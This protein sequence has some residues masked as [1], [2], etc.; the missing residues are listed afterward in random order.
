MA[1]GRS[2]RTPEKDERLLDKLRR[3]Y[4]VAAA[5]RAEGIGRTSYYERHKDD[6]AFAKAADD[7]IEEGTDLLEDIA[8]KRAVAPKD[9]SDTLLI[10]LLKGR[11]PEKYRDNSTMRHEG[12][13]GGPLVV[14]LVRHYAPEGES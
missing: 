6:P 4:S 3:G 7:A 14:S 9:A 1:Q 12:P 5:C 13:D 2:H 8:R 10:F 11:R